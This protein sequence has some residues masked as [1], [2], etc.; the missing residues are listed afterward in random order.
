MWNI[1]YVQPLAFIICLFFLTFELIANIIVSHV[2][3][4]CNKQ[5]H[6][7]GE[8]YKEDIDNQQ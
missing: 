8:N 6:F 1:N 3:L 5:Q 4:S 2:E 7:I